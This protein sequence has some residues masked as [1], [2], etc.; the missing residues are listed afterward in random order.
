VL[1]NFESILQRII[2][3]SRLLLTLG[4]HNGSLLMLAL[5]LCI[6]TMQEWS[7]FL[8]LPITPCLQDHPATYAAKRLLQQCMTHKPH[9]RAINNCNKFLRKYPPTLNFSDLSPFSDALFP[10]FLPF[11]FPLKSITKQQETHPPLHMSLD[12]Q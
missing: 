10:T 5:F 8:I 1:S 11:H 9:A 3:S 12:L 7:V 2:Y 4:F 6:C